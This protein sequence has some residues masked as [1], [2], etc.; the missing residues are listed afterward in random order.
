MA[1]IEVGTSA[2]SK[3]C[4]RCHQ[5]DCFDVK[6]NYCERC[7]INFRDQADARKK[8]YKLALSVVL[9]ALYFVAIFPIAESYTTALNEVV[10]YSLDG[11]AISAIAVVAIAITMRL[12]G[13]KRV[14]C[15]V[16]FLAGAVMIFKPFIAP[17]KD[18]WPISSDTGLKETVIQAYSINSETH[19]YFL[20][21]GIILILIGA[22][23]FKFPGRRVKER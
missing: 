4:K 13:F 7:N 10:R 12:L 14:S 11:I 18:L 9:I 15:G 16:L 5:S 19:F 1:Q 20:I 17:V 3:K 6:R 2:A 22:V 23:L 8:K 21:P